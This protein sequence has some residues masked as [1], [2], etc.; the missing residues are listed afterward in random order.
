MDKERKDEGKMSLSR[1]DFLKVSAA[2]AT[3]VGLAEFAQVTPSAAAVTGA[4]VTHHTTCPYCSASCGQLVA[5][6]AA[7]PTKKVGTGKVIDVYGDHRSP[8]N[9]GGLCAKGAGAYQLV[10]N[11]RRVGAWTAADLLA[12]TGSSNHP[13]DNVFRADGTTAG[14]AYRRKGNGSWTAISIDTAMTEIVQGYNDG[15]H[16]H[17]GLVTYR[18]TVDNTNKY[19]SKNVAFF[20]SSHMNNECNYVY[21]K[22]TCNF[23]TNNVEHQARI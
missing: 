11:A 16:S 21:K 1:R 14:K 3:A 15:S 9:S 7:D 22:I 13:V 17:S 23:G 10:N 5:V 19:N 2:G 12:M 18:G 4:A 20:G 6:D 8:F